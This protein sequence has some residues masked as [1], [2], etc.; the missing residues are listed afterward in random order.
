MMRPN[1]TTTQTKSKTPIPSTPNSPNPTGLNYISGSGTWK[2]TNNPNDQECAQNWNYYGNDKKTLYQGNI[3][4]ITKI[5]DTENWCPLK[6]TKQYPSE[7]SKTD[8]N[9]SG[10]NYIKNSSTDRWIYTKNSKNSDCA[11]NWNYYDTN[12]KLILGNIPNITTEGDKNSWCALKTKLA[13]NSTTPNTNGLDYISGSGSGTWKYTED[14]KDSDCANNWNYYDKDKKLILGN[15]PNITKKGDSKNW[16]ALKT[17]TQTKTECVGEWKPDGKGCDPTTKKQTLVYKVIDGNSCPNK[18]G[19]TKV[20]DCEIDCVGGYEANWGSCDASTGKQLKLCKNPTSAP[21]QSQ[22]CKV[23]CK[24]KYK[25]GE[26]VNGKRKGTLDIE[27]TAKN[28]GD[29]CP[30]DKTKED[31]CD[32]DCVGSWGSWEPENCP[33]GTQTRTYKVSQ[34]KYG[35]G[36]ACPYDD[37]TTETK[38]CSAPTQPESNVDCVASWS[39]FGDCVDGQKTKTYTVTTSSSGSGKACETFDGD[40]KTEDCSDAWYKNPM[41]L[42]GIGLGV[43]L[44]IVLLFFMMKKNPSVP[45]V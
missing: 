6:T 16:C 27:V 13:E 33:N 42:G 36:T 5:G 23:D 22:D 9:P 4:N 10:L 11:N 29:A 25:Y 21:P 41:I 2:Y 20:V 15:I 3:P 18:T 8:P 19:D 7:N 24:Y 26:C 43:L 32:I 38:T 34:P 14:P 30:T 37:K 12:G 39:E 28:K 1:P 44:L 31:D 35:N 17:P 45:V 40:T